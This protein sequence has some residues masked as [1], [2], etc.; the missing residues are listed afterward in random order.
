MHSTINFWYGNWEKVC[1][2]RSWQREDAKKDGPALHTDKNFI[3]NWFLVCKLC[4]PRKKMGVKHIYT[5]GISRLVI[6]PMEILDKTKLFIPKKSCK[7]IWHLQYLEKITIILTNPSFLLKFST[8]SFRHVSAYYQVMFNT[9]EQFL[10]Y[11]FIM[12]LKGNKLTRLN[13]LT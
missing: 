3:R 10:F 2:K 11:N 6:S 8:T 9:D 1:M 4:Y 12:V 13:K 7:I 5:A